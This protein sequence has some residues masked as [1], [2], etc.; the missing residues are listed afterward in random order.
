MT[1]PE[2]LLTT[3]HLHQAAA[4]L[5]AWLD[6]AAQEELGYADFLG[7]LLDEEVAARTVAETQRR[8]RQAGF[9]FAA[10]IE[11]FDFRFRPDLKRQVVLRY[12]DP[13]FVD[14]AGTL[15][16]V[17]P[18]GLGKTM[19]AICIATKQVQLGASAR[20]V[21]AQTLA[22][23][24]GRSAT[25]VGRQRLLKPLLTC[26]VL[27]LDEL[28]YLPTTPSFGPALYEVI[29]GRYERRPT[30]ITSNKSLS[31]WAGIVQDVSLAA[32]I[33]DRLMHH[34][35]VFYLKGP[36]WRTRGRD[37]QGE[38]VTEAVG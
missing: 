37:A 10:T 29:A 16:L 28:G 31:E 4:V 8:L 18:P 34:G 38:L 14:Q 1:A 27:V 2:A 30:I 15:T 5:P 7:G 35:Q 20:F 26:D 22:T 32:A 9:P 24:V 19:L 21:T 12:L 17:G 36:S 11:Q 25:V 33:V 6:R 3:L 13:T 23:Q